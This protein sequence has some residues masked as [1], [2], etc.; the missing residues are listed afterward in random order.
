MKVRTSRPVLAVLGMSLFAY[1]SSELFTAGA[2][3]PMH[4][5]LGV[6]TDTIGSLV[7][8]YA[9]V[10]AV[11]LLPA[12]AL[13][14]RLAPRRVLVGGML[15]LAISQAA[16]TVAP[17]L[18]Y[19]ELARVFAA[20]CHGLVWAAVPVVAVSLMPRQPGKATAVV[21]LG[22][23]LGTVVGSPLVAQ[24][25]QLGSWRLAAAL[26]GVL[27]AGCAVGLRRLVPDLPA[28]GSTNPGTPLVPATSRRRVAR[29]C[30]VIVPIAAAYTAS[31]TYI[32]ETAGQAGVPVRWVPALMLTM[33]M[34][35][36]AS[37]VS[38]G[39]AHDRYPG[40]A[41]VLSVGVLAGGFALGVARAPV[42]VI[43]ALLWAAAYAALIVQFQAFVTEDSPGWSR[44][45]SSFY[46]L[47]F[48][49]G[50][51]AG[52]LL[53]GRAITGARGNLAALSTALAIA[54]ALLTGYTVRGRGSANAT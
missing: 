44:L 41:T 48:Q 18:T 6:S 12:A 43:G 2:L 49:I 1:A 16:L 11:T 8:T 14:R 22:G 5:D 40:A 19:V 42:F 9:V 31:Y 28:Q 33:G 54:G 25:S 37:T 27:A 24:I 26:L 51:A 29:W 20:A 50:I 23:S 3:L 39:R 30:I 10:A 53:G 13:T 21:F 45:A 17:S 38:A 4:E 15:A 7:T 46:V 32:A 47:A 35:G 36:L 52:G 34:G